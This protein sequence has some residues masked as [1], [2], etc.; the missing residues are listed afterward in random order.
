MVLAETPHGEVA[1]GLPQQEPAP[2]RPGRSSRKRS[3]MGRW[4]ALLT[5]FALRPFVKNFFFTFQLQLTY[6]IILVS[7]IQHND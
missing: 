2:G 3:E 7:G 5:G 1:A 4:A 6:N